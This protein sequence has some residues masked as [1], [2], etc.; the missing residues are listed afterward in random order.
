MRRFPLSEANEVDDGLLMCILHGCTRHSLASGR[1]TDFGCRRLKQFESSLSSLDILLSYSVKP[2]LVAISFR[3][4]FLL[5]RLVLHGPDPSVAAQAPM[6]F[7]LA[8][9]TSF[10]FRDDYATP[11]WQL[12]TRGRVAAEFMERLQN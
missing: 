1:F 7:A 6:M 8:N 9:K 3:H 11:A 12:L 10:R 4:R 5:G 2:G